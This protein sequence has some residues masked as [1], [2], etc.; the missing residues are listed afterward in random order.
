MFGHDNLFFGSAIFFFRFPNACKLLF[1]LG[2]LE[3]ARL[4]VFWEGPEA[5]G[6]LGPSKDL[7]VHRVGLAS[8]RAYERK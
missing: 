8:D 4:R 2:P 5:L 1:G 7:G 6:P 3:G